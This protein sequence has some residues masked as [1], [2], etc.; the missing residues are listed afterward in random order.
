MKQIHSADHR[1]LVDCM[2]L[3]M[4]RMLHI[5]PFRVAHSMDI[6]ICSHASN[7]CI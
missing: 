7:I 5:N 3:C 2:V 4:P 6:D 1:Y